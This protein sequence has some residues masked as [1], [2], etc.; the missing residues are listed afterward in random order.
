MTTTSS[1]T[2]A[3]SKIHS[4]LLVIYEAER[5]KTKQLEEECTVLMN[6]ILRKHYKNLSEAQ[7]CS[8]IRRKNIPTGAAK[9]NKIAAS[10]KGTSAPTGT[11]TTPP[12]ATEAEEPAAKKPKLDTDAKVES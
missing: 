12:D 6:L 10:E 5:T 11:T 9:K 3:S 1:S 7:H 4:D 8:Q 2:S